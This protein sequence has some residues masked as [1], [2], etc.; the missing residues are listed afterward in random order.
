MEEYSSFERFCG[1]STFFVSRM[2]YY[3][4]VCVSLSI[5]RSISCVC[6]CVRCVCVCACVCTRVCVL[7]A[8]DVLV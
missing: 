5:C 4:T 2:I 1:N 6:V 3:V 8:F 7:Y